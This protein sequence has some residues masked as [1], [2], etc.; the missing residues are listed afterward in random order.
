MSNM[1]KDCVAW[2][3]GGCGTGEYCRPEAECFMEE[4]RQ[5]AE[6][7]GH[8]LAEF[9]HKKGW[10]VWEARCTRCGQLAGI[11]LDP[12]PGEACLYGEALT[13]GCQEVVVST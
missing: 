3:L 11:N 7:S 5:S 9:V 4:A 6:Q 2:L 10:P 12:S 1:C 13:A 8:I